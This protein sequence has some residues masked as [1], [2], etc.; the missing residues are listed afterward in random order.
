M[1]RNVL[2]DLQNSRWVQWAIPI[3]VAALFVLVESQRVSTQ[4]V[5]RYPDFFAFVERAAR[6]DPA[7]LRAF[8]WAYGLYPLGYPLLLWAGVQLGLDVLTT[9]F[10]LSILGGVMGL[11]GTFAL[12]RM[13]SG[14][15]WLAAIS[16]FVLGCL[17]QYLFYGSN[18]ST[19]MLASGMA[20]VSLSVLVYADRRWRWA[21]LAGLVAG[22]S[23]LI[24][25]TASLTILLCAIYLFA[26][27]LA[28]RD[29][30]WVAAGAAFVVGAVIGGSPQLIASAIVKGNPFY[31]TQGHNLWF[32]LT[33]SMDFL[34]DWNKMPMDVSMLDVFRQFPRQV[35]DHWWLEFRNFWITNNDNFLGKPFYALLQ[36]GLLFAALW[37]G[38]LNRQARFLIALYA[39]GHL[40]LLSFMRLD[41]RFLLLV[42]PLFVFGVVYFLWQLIPRNVQA[43]RWTLPVRWPVMLVLMAWAATYP[44]GF[45]LTNAKDE[46]AILVS[47]VLHAA[48][49]QSY[50][51]VFSTELYLQDVADPWKRRFAEPA[52]TTRGL[53]SHEQLLDVLRRGNY[54]FFIY[55]K[56]TGNQLYPKLASLQF[57]DSRP[58]GLAPIFAPESGEFAAYRVTGMESQAYRS[59]DVTLEEGVRLIG[60]ETFLSADQPR[61]SGQRLGVYL[62]WKAERPLAQQLKVFVH[63]MNAEGKL[64][65][66]HDGEPQIGAYP[67][68]EWK[69]GETFVDFHALP[70]SA[71]VPPGEYTLLA[72]LYDESS[73][74]RLKRVDASGGDA[75]VLTKISLP[76]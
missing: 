51:D 1:K 5:A 54:R 7:N 71:N 66:Q 8:D 22:A 2:T 18:D 45:R 31:S 36:A 72:G 19:D 70:I 47:N 20:I 74:I 41:K 43:G 67:T 27:A 49:M 56:Q 13:L 61:G 32:T 30:A 62:Y 63:L 11:L 12:V 39:V 64:I 38:G 4:I 6:F 9:A 28:R 33:G 25:Y 37:R 44:L 15:Y 42:M 53:E 50:R 75:I 23:Y 14:D 29:R 68:N 24:R 65:T 73:G 76:K 57:P 21:G 10:V 52:L 26:L 40:A 46:R 59:L 17:G 60:Y 48:G 35:L 34:D 58:K 69:P 3:A 55:D 16:E